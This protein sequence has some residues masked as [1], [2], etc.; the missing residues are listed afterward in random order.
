MLT[1]SKQ[2]KEEGEKIELYS[3][4]LFAKETSTF[5]RNK[6]LTFRAEPLKEVSYFLESLCRL[7]PFIPH[8]R[9]PLGRCGADR[10]RRSFL[11]RCLTPGHL[12]DPRP[13]NLAAMGCL[14]YGVV[15]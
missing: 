9:S 4:N 7:V 5:P 14:H 15:L 2:N 1:G 8:H 6:V 12:G 3:G 13:G 11:T 10:R